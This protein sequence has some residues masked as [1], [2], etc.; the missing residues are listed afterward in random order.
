MF[1]SQGAPS[2]T[3]MGRQHAGSQQQRNISKMGKLRSM[4]RNMFQPRPAPS[5]KDKW[6]R[7]R[8]S[9]PWYLFTD[10]TSLSIFFLFFAG[11]VIIIVFGLH[12]R[13][14]ER[15]L[16]EKYPCEDVFGTYY[17]Q[18]NI[19]DLP[20]FSPCRLYPQPYFA[21]CPK[22]ESFYY[23]V[24]QSNAV[25]MYIAAS[26]IA[27][28][29]SIIIQLTYVVA[30][31]FV[32]EVTHTFVGM[33]LWAAMGVA[34]YAESYWA[35]MWGVFALLQNIY[36]GWTRER[37]DDAVTV[38]T[39]A[40]RFFHERRDL[41]IL[42][43]TLVIVQSG[44]FVA[45][46]I[47]YV[48]LNGRYGELCDAF[49]IIAYLWV[50]QVIR[51]I[52]QIVAA[53]VFGKWYFRE[54]RTQYVSISNSR[55]RGRGSLNENGSKS[56][57]KA[58][59]VSTWTVLL[60][61]LVK[62]LGS[63][64]FS[65]LTMALIKVSRVVYGL[66]RTATGAGAA[67]FVVL[68]IVADAVLS[69]FNHY[70]LCRIVMYGDSFY[71]SSKDAFALLTE[72]GIQEMMFDDV[73]IVLNTVTALASAAG[74]CLI[75]FIMIHMDVVSTKDNNSD[76]NEITVIYLP[77]F[78]IGFTVG[79]PV[80]DTLEAVVMSLY[81]C[82][83]E[84]PQTLEKSDLELYT[85]LLDTWFDVQDDSDDDGSADN[86]DISYSSDDDDDETDDDNDN[87]EDDK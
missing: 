74:S 51:M 11:L 65:A 19:D 61:T 2:A 72:S 53:G 57:R 30:S 35:I 70:G 47:F 43:Y 6:R 55:T 73:I 21:N 81:M 31:E 45:F 64:C 83:A 80:L 42:S 9:T 39:F 59:E 27:L 86:S 38:T 68:A 14:P 15:Y 79:C 25:S 32:V 40:F 71:K 48:T 58:A 17:T 62:H 50:N 82:F 52:G 4:A 13:L 87:D 77:C 54:E 10:L 22:Y 18:V 12:E 29:A 16:C 33:I 75:A 66:F 41:Q 1:G 76:I 28:S 24:M 23:E 84:E 46:I 60:L 7:L 34:I 26:L 5:Q 8:F 49:V 69:T 36:G 3:P 78:I 20:T 37:M 44:L 56:R 63:V 85:D 67:I